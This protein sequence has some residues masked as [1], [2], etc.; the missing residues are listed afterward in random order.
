MNCNEYENLITEYLEETASPSH[1]I[2]MESH[3]AECEKCRSLA[4][5][6]KS[7]MKRLSA[8]PV[9]PCPD[10]VIDRVME[11]ITIPGMSLKESIR[12]WLQPGLPRRFGVASLTASFVVVAMLLLFYIPGQ[13]RQTL[14]AQKFSPREIQQA[15]V[16]AKLALAY[17]TV[18][19]RKAEATLEKIDLDKP[20][21]KP[22]EREFKKALGKIPYI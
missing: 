2:Q 14:E 1:R 20:V 9:E 15:T 17:F 5:L 21:M 11:T 16:E 13:Q 19:S 7:V 4:E 22:M 3:L 12:K 10:E 18:Y 8:I 6:E